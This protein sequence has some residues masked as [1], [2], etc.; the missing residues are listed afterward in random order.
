MLL[1]AIGAGTDWD[2]ATIV[3]ERLATGERKVLVKGGTSPRYLPG[4]HLVYARAGGLYAIA[5]EGGES[6][7]VARWAPDLLR[8]METVY[9]VFTR[10]RVAAVKMTRGP[11]SWNRL[12]RRCGRIPSRTARLA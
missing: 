6:G 1:Y 9:V 10:P 4:G 2:E 11:P 12:A 8:W 5:F 3:A 7:L